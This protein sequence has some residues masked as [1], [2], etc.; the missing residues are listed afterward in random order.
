ME[1][2]R[3]SPDPLTT[4]R[5]VEPGFTPTLSF[6][7]AGGAWVARQFVDGF[8][9]LQVDPDTPDVIA[10]QFCRPTAV[11]RSA[12]D[13][14][15]IGASIDAIAELRANPDLAVGATTAT[16]IAGH[17]ARCIDIE[18][19]TTPDADPPIFSPVIRV[20]AGPIALGSARRLRTWWLDI[21]DG[22]L[23][24]LVGGSIAAWDGAL[25]AAEPV[26]ASIRLERAAGV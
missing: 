26:V 5:F 10:V 16:T 14:V 9:D 11:Y 23:V 15:D 4:G 19:T 18:T 1:T 25:A 17:P 22:P 13:A 12:E 7:V 3:R 8:F 6:A 2:L 24:I 21:D 20:A